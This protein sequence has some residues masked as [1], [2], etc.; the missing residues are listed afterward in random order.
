MAEFLTGSTKL[1]IIIPVWNGAAYI[2]RALDS[3]LCQKEDVEVIVVDDGST[4]TT[5]MVVE[6]YCA[7]D[8]RIHILRNSKQKGV[9]GARLCGAENAHGEFLFF[10]DAD[11]TLPACLSALK[12]SIK[13]YPDS[14]MF[15]GDINDVEGTKNTIRKYADENINTGH[16]LFDWIIEN[17]VGYIWGK[18]I[19]RNLFLTL[20][21]IP[22]SLKFCEDYIQ[23]MQLSY[24]SKHVIHIGM[25]TYNY[26]Q[27]SSSACN[28]ILSRTAFADRFY[29]LCHHIRLIIESAQFDEKSVVQLK[30]KFLYYGRLFLWVNGKWGQDCLELQKFFDAYLSDKNVLNDYRFM[31]ERYRQTYW[32]ARCPGIWSMLYVLLLK[33][34]YHRIK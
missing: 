20:K 28:G 29:Q 23:M 15:I 3:I 32:T 21:V 8:S 33:Y 14:D 2:E 11:D 19:R 26:F 10:M 30:I 9:T 34:K 18:A 24:A 17:G 13:N 1:S 27:N 31:R 22:F 16:Q 6:A 7:I 5:H 12:T 25:P 4:D